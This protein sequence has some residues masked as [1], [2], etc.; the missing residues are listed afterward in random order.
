MTLEYLSI[1]YY[2][3][4]DECFEKG[5]DI[6]ISKTDKRHFRAA[7][8]DILQ[9]DATK[10]KTVLGWTHKHNVKSLMIDMVEADLKRYYKKN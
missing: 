10:A 7:E 5:T 6:I 1:S 9:G 8:V 4:G 2:W 3:K